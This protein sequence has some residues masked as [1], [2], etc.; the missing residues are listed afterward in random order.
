MSVVGRP[1]R[2]LPP[3]A[4]AALLL[5]GGCVSAFTNGAGDWTPADGEPHCNPAIGF[6][7][8]VGLLALSLKVAPGLVAGVAGGCG[9][10]ECVVVAITGGL[11]AIGGP[12][13]GVIGGGVKM[14]S[15][16]RAKSAWRRLHAGADGDPLPRDAS[17]VSDV[18]AL[19]TIEITTGATVDVYGDTLI[20]RAP[21]VELCTSSA[22]FH[23]VSA[24]R[25]ELAARGITRASCRVGRMSIWDGSLPP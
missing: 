21:S 1:R 10:P 7:A 16:S 18:D 13:I 12:A 2:V 20:L 23:E 11:F 17:V 8:D 3:L 19:R 5:V 4:V 14:H 22:W 9:Y 25:R 15:C 6:A 24:F